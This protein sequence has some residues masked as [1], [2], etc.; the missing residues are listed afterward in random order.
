MENMQC[1]NQLRPKS[2]VEG[3]RAR[4]WATGRLAPVTARASMKA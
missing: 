1:S 3:G 4:G 2:L